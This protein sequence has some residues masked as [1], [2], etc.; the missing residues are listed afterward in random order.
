LHEATVLRLNSEKA[1]AELN[2]R[3]S[4]PAD[5]LTESIAFWYR[6]KDAGDNIY[7]TCEKQIQKYG[8]L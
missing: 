5:E 6:A 2:W 3:S 1:R 8:K 7:T 4:V